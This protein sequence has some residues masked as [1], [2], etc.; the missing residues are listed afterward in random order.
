[1]SR[2]TLSRQ[3]EDKALGFREESIA[4]GKRSGLAIWWRIDFLVRFYLLGNAACGEHSVSAN[5]VRTLL[6]SCQFCATHE[7]NA[8]CDW[9]KISPMVKD[10]WLWPLS[11]PGL[12]LRNVNNEASWTQG[13][14]GT[15]IVI[16][17]VEKKWEQDRYLVPNRK[18]RKEG[19]NEKGA[20]GWVFNIRGFRLFFFV[21]HSFFIFIFSFAQTRKGN[22]LSS[23]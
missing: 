19:R 10:V 20:I 12:V 1:M 4:G 6:V 7:M 22:M 18:G 21:I 23:A 14:H 17:Y 9:V 13:T 8:F 11:S 5:R 2:F 3:L 15:D 16:W